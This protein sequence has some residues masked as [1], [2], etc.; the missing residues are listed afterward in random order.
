MGQV[1]ILEQGSPAWHSWRKTGIGASAA[2]VIEGLSP[3]KTERQLYFEYVGEIVDDEPDESSEFIFAKGHKTEAL[4]REHFQKIVKSII[5]PTCMQHSKYPWMLASLDGFS[6]KFG[7][8]EAKLVGKEALE[9]A[10]NG[11]LPAHHYSQMQHQMEVAETDL[12]HWFGHDGKKDGALIEVRRNDEYIKRLIEKEHAFWERV[13]KHQEPPL[14]ERDYL[15]PD[16]VSM[17]LELRDA[18]EL[19][20]NASIAFDQMKAK[21]A[22]H[23]KHPRIKGAGIK[24]FKVTREGSISLAKIPEIAVLIEAESKKLKPEYLETFRGKGSESWTIQIEKPKKAA[25]S[26]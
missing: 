22:A 18:K 6:S 1:V 17:L 24:L 14:S 12:G 15:I 23:Y 16:D 21:V 7:V 4:V 25:K 8:L 11:D 19:A 5:E 26:E 10:K 9:F 2:P 3:Y 13:Q 20:E